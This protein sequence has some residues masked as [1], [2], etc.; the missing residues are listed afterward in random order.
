[1]LFNTLGVAACASLFTKKP[2]QIDWWPITRDSL[3]FSFNICVLVAMAWDSV[4]MWWETVILLSL[5][6][7]YWLVMFQN[8]KIMKYV[9]R[10]IE[11][12][13]MWCQRIK[14]FDI[15]KQKPFEV[16]PSIQRYIHNGI[17]SATLPD[18]DKEEIRDSY[19]AY[20]N[21]GFESAPS[22]SIIDRIKIR[23]TRQSFDINSV[24][25][26][27]RK[28]RRQSFD[29]TRIDEID[30]DEFQI[31]EI[32]KGVSWFD[33]IWYFFTWPIRFILHYT[34]PDPIK[35]KKWFPLTFILCIIWIG[36]VAYVVFWMVVVIGDTFGI[37]EA[38]MGFTLLAAGGCLPEAI[39]AVIVTRKGSGQMG[40]SNSIGSNSLAILF[41]LGL[42]WFIRTMAD[43]A[44]FAHNGSGSFIRITSPGMEFIIMGLL[45]AV[46]AL[47][48][49]LA[50]AG[51]KLR[52]IV[53]GSLAIFYLLLAAVAI[54]VEL[55][56]F[57]ESTEE[58]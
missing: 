55:D 19:K 51:F 10:I 54:L 42:P 3:V 1:M 21:Q 41:S 32:P 25:P 28:E 20:D 23:E 15:V 24:D 26:P 49:T 56:V 33:I 38:I 8:P 30:E 17:I 16:K 40:V 29:L 39:S 14:N 47:Y 13:F 31:W 5:Y 2:I 12:R 37:P 6:V 4:I 45:L 35:Y 50:I 36:V 48:I 58:C 22:I 34:I 44:G 11:D 52:K 9:K 43:G 57:V 18:I 27:V 46:A 7:C 53:G